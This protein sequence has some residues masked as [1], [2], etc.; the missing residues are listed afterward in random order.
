MSD[1]MT[2]EQIEKFASTLAANVVAQLHVQVRALRDQVYGKPSTDKN[3]ESCKDEW[4]K[5]LDWLRNAANGIL[6]PR[7]KPKG[8]IYD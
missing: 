3:W 7:P 8:K 4:L 1:E 2:E 5:D 6:P